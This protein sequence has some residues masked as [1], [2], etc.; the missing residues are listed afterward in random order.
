MSQPTGTESL[1]EFCRR[2]LLDYE[3]TQYHSPIR[4]LITCYGQGE[5]KKD[6]PG[7]PFNDYGF[8]FI[9]LIS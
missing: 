9:T 1:R 6:E 5:L 8:S 4:I 2:V 7:V 3:K